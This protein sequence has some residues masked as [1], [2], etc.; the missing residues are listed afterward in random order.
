MLNLATQ[1]LPSVIAETFAISLLTAIVLK[2]TLELILLA[3]GWVVHRIRSA[4][5][6]PVRIVTVLMLVVLLPLSKILVLELI[7]F[8]FGNAVSLGGFVSV[9][10][11]IITL[12][13]ARLGVR[14]L[15][16]PYTSRPA[17]DRL[18]ENHSNL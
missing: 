17:S 3:K 15:L 1:F 5:T 14:W 4:S 13:L 7:G 9:T 2:V 6:V 16:T 18:D 12:V 8:L 10:L 11:L